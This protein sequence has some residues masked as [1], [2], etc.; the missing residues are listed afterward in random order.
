M[1][2]M[3]FV[4]LGGVLFIIGVVAGI[5]SATLFKND[6]AEY[7]HT[8]E[9]KMMYWMVNDIWPDPQVKGKEIELPASLFPEEYEILS[10]KTNKKVNATAIDLD[11]DSQAEYLVYS[12]T[13]NRNA[14]YDIFKMVNGKL[15]ECGSVGGVDF[16]VIKHNGRTGIFS[17]WGSGVACASYIYEQ[18]VNGKM[19][20]V[21]SFEVDGS[22]ASV[23]GKN[24]EMT[25]RLE[26]SN[27]FMKKQ[28]Q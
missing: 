20:T 21:L 28:Y 7:E 3:R 1:K 8:L 25:I 27:N 23:P 10:R 17:K 4:A 24:D 26:T 18:L 2:K 5:F 9:A 15:K 13:G 16:V 12:G 14:T 19:K 22:K 11:D 6:R